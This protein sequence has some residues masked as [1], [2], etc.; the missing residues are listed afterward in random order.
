MLKK[1]EKQKR[2]KKLLETDVG[3]G[4]AAFKNRGR[5]LNVAYVSG[6]FLSRK[7]FQP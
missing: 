6:N 2:F 1:S 4:E 5:Q 3:D 7:P